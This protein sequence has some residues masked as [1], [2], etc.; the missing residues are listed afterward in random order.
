[1]CAV[2][3]MFFVEESCRD[4]WEDVKAT[5]Y[6]NFGK[7]RTKF[8]SFR[9]WYESDG[10]QTENTEEKKHIIEI[11][12]DG[13]AQ[14]NNSG[15]Q[16]QEVMN[17]D[18]QIISVG[19]QFLNSLDAEKEIM[20]EYDSDGSPPKKMKCFASCK[21][22]EADMLFFRS[23]LPDLQRMNHKQK[24]QFKRNVLQLVGDVLYGQDSRKNSLVV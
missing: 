4:I 20:E 7:T 8:H 24:N 14:L 22:D 16:E 23:M 6:H 2:N 19:E 10:L 21:D 11:V 12:T 5:Y 15:V 18:K 3:H 9:N 17:A 13:A 1:M